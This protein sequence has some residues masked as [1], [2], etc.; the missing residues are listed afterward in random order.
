MQKHNEWLS[1]KG[2]LRHLEVLN[3]ISQRKTHSLN[4]CPSAH[5]RTAPLRPR[6]TLNDS[7]PHDDTLILR[8][9]PSPREQQLLWDNYQLGKRI[10]ETP[11]VISKKK[12]DE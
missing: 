6:P 9:E 12:M 4:P 7:P 2:Y 11:P 3:K 8:R 10:V 1:N 5:N